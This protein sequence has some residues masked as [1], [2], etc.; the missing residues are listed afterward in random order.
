M[1][2][3][4]KSL[5]AKLYISAYAARLQNRQGMN[6]IMSLQKGI[7]AWERS[8]DR[9]QLMTEWK[10]RGFGLDESARSL[11]ENEGKPAPL[12]ANLFEIAGAK[13]LQRSGRRP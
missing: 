4:D 2:H 7:E 3:P 13:I 6:M 12:K 11:R 8:E 1:E 9:A 5:E 10:R